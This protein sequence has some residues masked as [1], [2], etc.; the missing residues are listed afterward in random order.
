MNLLVFIFALISCLSAMRVFI[1]SS[2]FPFCDERYDPVKLGSIYY[3]R[4]SRPTVEDA[5]RFEQINVDVVSPLPAEGFEVADDEEQFYGSYGGCLADLMLKGL[6]E[7]FKTLLPLLSDERDG[8]YYNAEFLWYCMR[9]GNR[10]EYAEFMMAQGVDPNNIIWEVLQMLQEWLDPEHGI[11][12]LQFLLARDPEAAEHQADIYHDALV[13]I[14]NNSELS[15]DEV[16]E[17]VRRLTGLGADVTDDLLDAFIERFPDNSAF[18][19]ML[20]NAQ[21]PDCKGVEC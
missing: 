2:K 11:D 6:W 15:E 16:V 12:L 21:V 8:A 9:A 5:I 14:H 18:H 7:S 10:R 19:E 17:L 4:L 3:G 1:I 20:R 13:N